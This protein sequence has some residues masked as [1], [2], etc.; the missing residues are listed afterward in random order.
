MALQQTGCPVNT[1]FPDYEHCP[2]EGS[3][4]LPVSRDSRSHENLTDKDGFQPTGTNSTDSRGTQVVGL[5]RGLTHHSIWAA[6]NVH[7]TLLSRDTLPKMK[8]SP[9]YSYHLR[10][11]KTAQIQETHVWKEYRGHC[12]RQGQMPMRG[13]DDRAGGIAPAPA[14]EDVPRWSQ[15]SVVETLPNHIPWHAGTLLQLRDAW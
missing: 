9:P 15:L 10:I 2:S 4:A 14:R 5:G 11:S 7:K 3:Q 6:N 12:P 13:G 8:T 1:E